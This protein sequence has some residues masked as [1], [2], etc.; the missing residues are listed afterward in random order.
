MSKKR[1]NLERVPPF[2]PII[3]QDWDSSAACQLMSLAEEGI[4]FRLIRKLWV[5]DELPSKPSKLAH[6]IGVAD[7]RTMKGW[8]DKYSHLLALGRS[9][10][11]ECTVNLREIYGNLPV[12][13]REVTCK[14]PGNLHSEKL[15]NLKKDVNSQVPLGSN[16]TEP[17]RTLTEPMLVSQLVSQ[18]KASANADEIQP[19]EKILIEVVDRD[20]A[21]YDLQCYET[22]H[23]EFGSDNQLSEITV[24]EVHTALSNLGKDVAWMQGCIQFALGHKAF[25]SK[26][27]VS[28]KS[29][30]QQL[31]NGLDDPEGTKL[32]AQYNRYATAKRRSAGAGK[33]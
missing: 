7:A 31:I 27:V 8:L 11:S 5:L 33:K 4:Y 10:S 18:L 2:I 3:W 15:R 6:I 21:V 20:T 16:Q 9:H 13:S 32:P 1:D 17:N 23:A 14:C 30:A 22:L 25:W 19:E 26:R 24:R 29:F 28:A 12:D